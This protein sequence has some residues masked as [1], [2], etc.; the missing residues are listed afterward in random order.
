[1]SVAPVSRIEFTILDDGHRNVPLR[2]VF[3]VSST[4]VSGSGGFSSKVFQVLSLWLPPSLCTPGILREDRW[5]RLLG[6]L[7]G[8]VSPSGGSAHAGD[9]SGGPVVPPRVGLGIGLFCPVGSRNAED[10]S[11]GSVVPRLT[12]G[13]DCQSPASSGR[14]SADLEGLSHLELITA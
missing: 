10:P 1:M 2:H 6:V 13:M 5:C 8:Q 11:G 12:G 3:P 9:P 7:Q 4:T 14:D